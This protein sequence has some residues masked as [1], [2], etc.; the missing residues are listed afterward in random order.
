ME[1]IIG[2]LLSLLPAMVGLHKWVFPKF[3][4]YA[5]SLMSEGGVFNTILGGLIKLIVTVVRLP[6][7][8]VTLISNI[9]LNIFKLFSKFMLDFRYLAIISMVLSDYFSNLFESI[10]LIVGVVTIKIGVI[11]VKWGKG[12]LENVQQNNVNELKEIL[13]NNVGNLPPCMVDVMGYMHIVE[14][15]GMLVSALVFCGVINIIYAYVFKIK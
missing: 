7:F 5:S 8:L 10:F 15:I 6:Y 11:I 9:P 1:N 4:E 2:W 3:T 12:F 14:N 13:S